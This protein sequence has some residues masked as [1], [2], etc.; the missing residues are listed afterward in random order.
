[1]KNRCVGQ[2][3]AD[4]ELLAVT[5]ISVQSGHSILFMHKHGLS[6][7]KHIFPICI[8]CVLVEVLFFSSLFI[9]FFLS[10]KISSTLSSLCSGLK[11]LLAVSGCRRHS[12]PLLQE[13]SRQSAPQLQLMRAG[14]K[15]WQTERG[16]GG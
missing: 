5:N 10:L 4:K 12:S 3:L 14:V 9:Y 1:M 11:Q 13:K 6:I 15:V 16:D 8:S 2:Y 7:C